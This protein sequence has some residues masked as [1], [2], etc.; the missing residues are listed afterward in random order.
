MESK[1]NNELSFTNLIE[2]TFIIDKPKKNYIFR[3]CKFQEIVFKVR[4]YNLVQYD[5]GSLSFEACDIQD[6]D[7]S[8]LE[9]NHSVVFS[10][11]SIKNANFFSSYF[12]SGI[13]IIK[14]AFKNNINFSAG[15]NNTQGEVNVK[16]NVFNDFVDFSDAYFVSS[17]NI[18][19]NNFKGGS[20]LL[21]NDKTPVAV[22]FPGDV[23][24]EDNIGKIDMDT[25]DR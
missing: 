10:N 18:L 2:D 16:H 15:F 7:L 8:G 23:T 17:V 14:T 25:Y 21:G 19:G 9:F 20:N 5:L 11:C 3:N 6:I 22:T 13:D 4:D 24:I 1:N 12:L